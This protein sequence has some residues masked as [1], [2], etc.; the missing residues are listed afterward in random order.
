M[1]DLSFYKNKKVFITGHTGF[2]GT[3]LC[4]ILVNAGAKVI[5]YSLNPPTKPNLFELSGIED[6]M[7]SYIGDIRDYDSLNQVYSKSQPEIVFHLA[8]QPIVRDSYN[9]VV[10]SEMSYRGLTCSTEEVLKDTIRG[11]LCIA[12]LQLFQNDPLVIVR[13]YHSTWNFGSRSILYL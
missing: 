4:K 13:S 11:C 7:E 2:K 1:L 10:H 8:A 5:G 12:L 9:K 3:W 6:E